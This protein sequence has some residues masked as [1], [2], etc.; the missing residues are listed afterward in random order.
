MRPCHPQRRRWPQCSQTPACD[1]RDKQEQI[2]VLRGPTLVP[3][4]LRSAL[5]N[6]CPL[7]PGPSLIPLEDVVGIRPRLAA[8]VVTLL[9]NRDGFAG[10]SENSAIIFERNKVA[11]FDPVFNGRDVRKLQ[12][13]NW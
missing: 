10:N 9:M 11:I 12:I 5:W 13:E 8:G 7:L 4:V 6:S 1:N 3:R 2:G